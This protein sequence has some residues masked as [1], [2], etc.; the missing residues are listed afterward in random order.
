MGKKLKK[1]SVNIEK[2]TKFIAQDR[3]IC[4]LGSKG[5]K[6]FDAEIECLSS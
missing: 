6:D 4:V 5:M 2:P 3:R 1:K